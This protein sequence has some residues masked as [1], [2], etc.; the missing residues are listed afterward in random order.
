VLLT[1]LTAFFVDR[2]ARQLDAQRGALLAR[3]RP[4]PAW[5]SEGDV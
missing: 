3:E 1:H 5:P 2:A 4:P